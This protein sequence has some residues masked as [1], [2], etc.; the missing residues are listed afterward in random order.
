MIPSNRQDIRWIWTGW[1]KHREVGSKFNLKSWLKI[2]IN[3][4]SDVNSLNH[5]TDQQQRRC[6]GTTR[7]QGMPPKRPILP[8][9][10]WDKNGWILENNDSWTNQF[11]VGSGVLTYNLIPFPLLK[12]KHERLRLQW[13][14]ERVQWGQ[15]RFSWK[16]HDERKR[17][18][19]RSGRDFNLT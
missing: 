10:K 13:C 17:V 19:G 8:L 12:W 14:Q 6:T 1:W 15:Y 5:R 18:P 16:I 11:L 4:N 2:S 7:S 9:E 3:W